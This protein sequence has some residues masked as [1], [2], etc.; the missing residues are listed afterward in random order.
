VIVERIVEAAA[1]GLAVSRALDPRL[2]RQ[3]L[4]RVGT[5]ELPC[6]RGRTVVPDTCC[7]TVVVGY[8]NYLG[9]FDRV[10]GGRTIMLTGAWTQLRPVPEG[11][12]VVAV[13]GAVPGT[14][15]QETLAEVRR[16]AKRLRQLR[17]VQ[18]AIRP[19]SPVIVVLLPFSPGTYLQA[20]LGVTALHGDFPEYPGGVRIELPV[21][22]VGFDLTRYAANLERLIKE[23]A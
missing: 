15:A 23:E 22:A 9:V 17:G 4:A 11:V 2:K 16:L 12:T 21:D 18:V 19:Q 14:V 13:E 3:L 20:L 1:G 5:S 6:V 10:G 7:D 8:P